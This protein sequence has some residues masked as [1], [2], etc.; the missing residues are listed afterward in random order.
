[1]TVRS[2][3]LYLIAA[4]AVLAGCT[5]PHMQT[6]AGPGMAGYGS[7]GYSGGMGMGPGMGGAHRAH[8]CAMHRQVMAGKSPTDQ[9]A[10]AEAQLRLMHGGNVTPDQARW[11]L[12][13]M[14]KY[15]ADA[16]A[17]P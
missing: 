1:M 3:S 9:L 10:A 17:K 5:A 8:M 16:G 13:R 6:G 2:L 7:G 11:H 14:D 4:I 15:C 12:E